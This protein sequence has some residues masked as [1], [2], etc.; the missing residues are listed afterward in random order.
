MP[1]VAA[2]PPTDRPTLP[3][4][5]Y[6]TQLPPAGWYPD[7]AGK[8]PLQYWD[9]RVWTAGPPQPTG[10]ERRDGNKAMSLMV[11]AFGLAG[12]FGFWSLFAMMI[13]ADACTPEKC[14]ESLI[15]AAYVVAW[16]GLP[17][18][19]IGGLVGIGVATKRKRP[20]AVPALLSLVAVVVIVIVWFTLMRLGTPSEMW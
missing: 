15:G 12:L 5:T 1:R 19:I 9:G 17:A 20:R 10:E 13:P 7:P 6:M 14:R 8:G 11:V 3:T 16:L 18:A 4:I 2:A